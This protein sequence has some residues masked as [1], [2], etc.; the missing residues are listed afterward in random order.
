MAQAYI[1]SPKSLGHLGDNPRNVIDLTDDGPPTKK[2]RANYSLLNESECDEVD[3]LLG[4]F[5]AASHD[6]QSKYTGLSRH[7][8]VIPGARMTQ[9]VELLST[10]VID[11]LTM[12]KIG[13]IKISV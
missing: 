4:R 6:D 13:P 3:E 7:P 2:L 1:D 11:K 5:V 10:V 9:L 8:I 12:P